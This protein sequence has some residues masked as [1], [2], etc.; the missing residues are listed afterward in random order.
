[1]RRM[2]GGLPFGS[3]AAWYEPVKPAPV[4]VF[5]FVVVYV[6]S[7]VSRGPLPG[8][9]LAETGQHAYSAPTSPHRTR[10]RITARVVPGEAGVRNDAH[11]GWCRRPAPGSGRGGRRPRGRSR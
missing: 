7:T 4:A 10:F 11:R 8:V 5:G 1:M 6:W 3:L 9:A 2:Y